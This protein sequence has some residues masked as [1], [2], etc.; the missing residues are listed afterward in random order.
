MISKEKEIYYGDKG[1]Y[2]VHYYA[3]S[4]DYVIILP[5]IFEELSRTRKVLVNLC[6]Y[7]ADRKYNCISFDYYGTGLSY[8]KFNEFSVT[9]ADT[10]K[11][12]EYCKGQDTKSLS[13]IGFRFGGYLALSQS[14][15]YNFKSI[16]LCEPILNLKNYINE[17]LRLEVTNQLITYGA[18]KYNQEKLH[19]KIKDE[20][21]IMIDGYLVSLL[22]YNQLLSTKPINA[23]DLEKYVKNV[24]L[25]LWT[26]KKLYESSQKISIY[27]QYIKP[28]KFSWK[29]IRFLQGA[30]QIFFDATFK[31][32]ERNH[33]IKTN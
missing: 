6:R 15:L 17:M 26:N 9:Q 19:E 11:V 18:V 31:G 28:I 14:H 20:K 4:E 7:L 10:E 8:G 12:V 27:S 1:L 29:H 21:E 33:E 2:L 24:K 23:K 30:P 25:I 22:F 13:L 5:P 16:I 3:D 32:L